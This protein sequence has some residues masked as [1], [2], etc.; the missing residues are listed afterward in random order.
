MWLVKH[1]TQLIELNDKELRALAD[2]GREAIDD[3]EAEEL[4]I[5]R[6]KHKVARRK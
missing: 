4:A 3:A 6:K 5:I 1:V 2:R